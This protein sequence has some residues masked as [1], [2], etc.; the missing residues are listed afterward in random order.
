MYLMVVKSEYH[1]CEELTWTMIFVV[2]VLQRIQLA[3]NVAR[4][5]SSVKFTFSNLWTHS[6]LSYIKD[7]YI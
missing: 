2:N 6:A 4:S 5:V 1:T 3:E 7:A